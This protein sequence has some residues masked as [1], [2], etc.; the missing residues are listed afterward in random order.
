VSS[1]KS[2]Q[3]GKNIHQNGHW[4]NQIDHIE[5][6][7]FSQIYHLDLT[8]NQI[9]YYDLTFSQMNLLI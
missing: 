9:D 4:F 5:W 3:N 6:I 1:Q 8:F 2:S 7:G